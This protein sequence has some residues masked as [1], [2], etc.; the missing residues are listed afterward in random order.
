MYADDIVIFYASKYP[1]IIENQLSKNMEDIINNCFT[2][3]LIINT[4]KGKSKVMLFGSSKRL[5][6][7]GKKLEITF[8]GKQINFVTN[9]KYLSFIISD[10]MTLNANFSRTYKTASTRLWLLSKMKS[11]ASVKARYTIC[12]S[13]IILLLTYPCWHAAYPNQPLSSHSWKV[14]LLSINVQKQCYP[15][16]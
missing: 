14:F 13:M 2:N 1:T 15:M 8:C 11:F 6:S 10:T 4:K 16:S 12:P 9:Y 5:K 7:S 3:E